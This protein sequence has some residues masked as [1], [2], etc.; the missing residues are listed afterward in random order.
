LPKQLEELRQRASAPA[1]QAL[2]LPFAAY[3]SAEI[4]QLERQQ[5]FR[6]DWIAICA[7]ADL[8]K[9][10][11][12]VA[13]R[14]AGEPVA[15]VR[16]ADHK[17]RALSNVC[18]HRG[19]ILLE[20]GRG[21]TQRIVCPYHAWTYDDDGRLM[22][23]PYAGSTEIDR[24]SH[25]LARFALEIWAGVVFVNLDRQA[26]SL[27]TVL[28]GVDRYVRNY[29]L[30]RYAVPATDW[31]QPELWHANWKLIFENAVE[32]YHLFKVHPKTFEPYV[33]TRGFFYLDGAAPW[34]VTGGRITSKSKAPPGEPATMGE[35]ERNNYI[36]VTIPPSF[37]GMVT[38]GSWSWLTVLPR[39]EVS[40]VVSQGSL[41]PVRPG[42]VSQRASD[43][44]NA[45]FMKEDRAIC[46]RAQRGMY[47]ELTA[48]GNLVEMERIVGD[49][50]QYLAWR[51]FGTEPEAR[52]RSPE[53]SI[54]G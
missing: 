34:T 14:I 18:R 41:V 3:R 49:F 4:Y 35:F 54:F 15:V 38:R 37:I 52:H 46:E 19:S 13:L 53:V 29:Q 10:G 12:Y 28:Q 24:E 11:D 17:L 1:G 7:A 50:H 45:A 32:S 16:G 8:A 21:N 27:A 40:S 42:R 47:A 30:D 9:P 25:G 43:A 33:P 44:F 5:V 51:L 23:V 20:E 26:E 2:A 22:G 48:G 39:D 31:R 36:L 6:R